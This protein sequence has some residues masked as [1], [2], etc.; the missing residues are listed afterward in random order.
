MH[1]RELDPCP[2]LIGTYNSCSYLPKALSK[3]RG[4]LFLHLPSAF[5][6]CDLFPIIFGPTRSKVVAMKAS[7]EYR[8]I[9]CFSERWGSGWEGA[10]NL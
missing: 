5:L 2:S 10:L 4:V 6:F 7:C 9:S 1:K 8:Q 3:E